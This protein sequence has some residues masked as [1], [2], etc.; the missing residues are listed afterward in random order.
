MGHRCVMAAEKAVILD[1]AA[2]SNST[3]PMSVFCLRRLGLVCIG[4]VMCLS[5]KEK[6]VSNCYLINSLSCHLRC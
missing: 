4:I 6:H 2:R 5:E 1:G 3:V